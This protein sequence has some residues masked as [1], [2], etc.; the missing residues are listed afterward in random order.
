MEMVI[1]LKIVYMYTQN[2]VGGEQNNG[3]KRKDTN[4]NYYNIVSNY[5]SNGLL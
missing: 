5:D 1:N 4:D 2:E 3:N